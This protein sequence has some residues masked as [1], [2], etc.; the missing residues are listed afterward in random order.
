MSFLAV[1]CLALPDAWALI[2]IT[3]AP[4]IHAPLRYLA[5]AVAILFFFF[6]WSRKRGATSRLQVPWIGYLLLISVV[7]EITFR[8]V[9]PHILSAYMEQLSAYI[10]SNLFFAV[11]HYV[12][13]RWRTVNCVTTFFGGMALSHLMGRGD[14]LLVILIHWVGTFINTPAP[15]AGEATGKG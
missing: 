3:T 2:T 4:V 14:L 10:V 12:T 11:I 1:I 9:L 6:Y 15:P 7:E 13:L 5:A 8:L